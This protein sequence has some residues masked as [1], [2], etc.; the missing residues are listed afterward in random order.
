MTRPDAHPHPVVRLALALEGGL[1]II[2]LGLGLV[3]G[4]QPLRDARVTA[5]ALA[6]GVAATLPTLL[7]M[8]WLS[9]T[10]WPPLARLRREVEETIV[11]LFA[12]CTM[13]ELALIALLAGLGEEVLFRGLVQRGMTDA[14]GP[15]VGLLVAGAL[16]GLAHF[17]THIYAVLAAVLGVYLGVVFLA[18]GNLVV[19]IIVHTLYDMAALAY[20]VRRPDPHAGDTAADQPDG[21]DAGAAGD[22]PT[23]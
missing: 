16:F 14:A 3:L 4:I 20:W 21:T 12:D 17:V 13:G 19:P 9:R 15:V 22:D 5:G 23:G 1:L 2:A 18:T 6:V 8:W 11:P 10:S 7:L